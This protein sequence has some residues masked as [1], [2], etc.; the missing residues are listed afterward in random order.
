MSSDRPSFP[1]SY[2]YSQDAYLPPGHDG[3]IPPPR[4]VHSGNREQY[5]P[6]ALGG[7]QRRNSNQASAAFATQAPQG[8]ALITGTNAE[9]V[10]EFKRR[11]GGKYHTHQSIVRHLGRWLEQNG[12]GTLADILNSPY[13]AY[14]N[15]QVRDWLNLPTDQ[16]P[17]GSASARGNHGGGGGGAVTAFRRA[18]GRDD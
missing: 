6:P 2:A 16:N 1:K 14:G 10:E 7:L 8:H 11:T 4:T 17:Y 5:V 18:F 9:L 13:S 12:L 3:A 15:D